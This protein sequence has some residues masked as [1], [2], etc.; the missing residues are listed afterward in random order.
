[1]P[2]VPASRL[3]LKLDLGGGLSLHLV[4]G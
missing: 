3:D 4:R 2:G 1:V